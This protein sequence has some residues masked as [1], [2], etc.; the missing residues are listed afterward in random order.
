MLRWC[1]GEEEDESVVK[2]I[3]F[4]SH[5]PPHPDLAD[6]VTALGQGRKGAAKTQVRYELEAPKGWISLLDNAEYQMRN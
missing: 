4:N 5:A 3:R 1:G 6:L 2:Q